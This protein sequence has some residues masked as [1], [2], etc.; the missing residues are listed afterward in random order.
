MNRFIV[1]FLAIAGVIG[2]FYFT[3]AQFLGTDSLKLVPQDSQVNKLSPYDEDQNKKTES[4]IQ[5]KFLSDQLK[6]NTS[7][8]SINLEDVLG[9]GP[10]KDGIPALTNPKYTSVSEANN[11]YQESTEGVLVEINDEARWISFDVLYWHEVINDT[12][13]ETP[14]A[15]TFCPLC[16]SAI[17]FER[18][19]DNGDLAEFGVSGKLWQSN[20][21]MYDKKTESLWS[22]IEGEAKVGDLTGTKLTILDSQIQSWAD[23]KNIE[24]LKVLS[25]DTGHV[26]DYGRNPYGT[27]EEAGELFFPVENLNTDLHP[28]TIM[29]A[30]KYKETSFALERLAL[31]SEKIL[32]LKTD[33]GILTVKVDRGKVTVTD[34]ENNTIPTFNTMWFSWANHWLTDKSVI[35]NPTQKDTTSIPVSTT[36]EAGTDSGVTITEYFSYGCYYCD[37]IHDPLHAALKEKPQ[38]KLELKHFIVYDEYLSIHEA[39]V[40]AAEQELGYEFHD[41][42]FSDHYPKKEA[43]VINAI[44]TNIGLDSKTL[45]DCLA[46]DRPSQKIRS[47]MQGGAL[48]GVRG[49]P[50]LLIKGKEAPLSVLSAREKDR[51]IEAI[52]TLE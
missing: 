1:P 38:T 32:E 23:V 37:V 41:A 28:K 39:Q 52:T 29:I 34:P 47:D 13:G 22:Q 16:G 30:G 8:T 35:W 36:N 44:S 27:Y 2:I 17:T 10:S 31:M 49:T 19:L 9:G 24:N 15:I 46:S 20:L 6:T 7:K 42:Y 25:H 48:I 14:V 3:Q 11:L 21:L 50:T 5:Q 40:C 4:K 26:R 51:I 33:D 45:K 12:I 18:K 43:S